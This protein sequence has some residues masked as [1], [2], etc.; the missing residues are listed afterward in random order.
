MPP[1]PLHR[2]TN[3]QNFNS[4]LAAVPFPL[5]A[6]WYWLLSE[7]V[8]QFGC[9]SVSICCTFEMYSVVIWDS[10]LTHL[11]TVCFLILFQE[12]GS[13]K[14]WKKLWHRI[15]SVI[16]NSVLPCCTPLLGFPPSCAGCSRNR[17]SSLTANQFYLSVH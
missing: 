16:I 7:Q 6:L 11:S 15:H 3:I 17:S 10:S 4:L 12:P 5:N 2:I 1:P 8:W 9:Y 14:F 13:C